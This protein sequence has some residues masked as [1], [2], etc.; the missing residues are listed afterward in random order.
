MADDF[1]LDEIEIAHG[2][3][4]P[5]GHYRCEFLGVKQATHEEYGAG[6]RFE[7]RVL[8]GPHA[9]AVASRTTSARPT[10]GNAGGRLISQI[11][12]ANLA[13]GQKVSL[14]DCVGRTFLVIAEPTKSGTG[15]RIGSV[16]AA[17]A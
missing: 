5:A 2:G 14:R 6:L 8:D 15:T 1:M 9:G 16:I 11:T 4:P 13:G 17:T 7:F 3:G 12:G 10:P